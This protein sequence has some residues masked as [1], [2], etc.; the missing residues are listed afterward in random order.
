MTLT[1]LSVIIPC[2]NP[3]K[4]WAK[5][6]VEYFQKIKNEIPG[7]ELVL[8]NDGSLKNFPI[9]EVN[10]CLNVITNSFERAAANLGYEQTKSSSKTD[11]KRK[12]ARKQLHVKNLLTIN[13]MNQVLRT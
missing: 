2:Y 6:V 8:V 12:A 10:I 11:Y 7:V 1:S 4:D 3:Q 9:E 5:N 13:D